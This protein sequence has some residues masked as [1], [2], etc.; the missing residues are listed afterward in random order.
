MTRHSE[1]AASSA[2]GRRCLAYA[3]IS[4]DPDN[5]SEAIDRQMA[6][7]EAV[8][9]KLGWEVEHVID[10]NLSAWKKKGSRPGFNRLIEE[11]ENGWCD[12]IIVWNIDRL[13]RRMDEL[14]EL[15]AA[16][17]KRPGVEIHT[18]GGILQLNDS[19]DRM[20]ARIQVLVAQAESENKSRRVKRARQDK[21]IIR[22][23]MGDDPETLMQ[24][25]T[26]FI[27]GQTT[28]QIARELN[29]EGKYFPMRAKVWRPTSIDVVLKN[30]RLAEF[31][32]PEEYMAVLRRFD[33]RRRA[34]YR[35]RTHTYLLSGIVQ[36]FECGQRMVGAGRKRTNGTIT[37]HYVHGINGTGCALSISPAEQ[38]DLHVIEYVKEELAGRLIVEQER[39]DAAIDP[40]Y[41]Q[42]I[43][44][45]E[46]DYYRHK[47]MS[48]ERFDALMAGIIEDAEAAA[49]P[50]VE[51]LLPITGD[52]LKKFDRAKPAQQ[53]ELL[54]RVIDHVEV[55]RGPRGRKG[56]DPSRVEI[57]TKAL[58]R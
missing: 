22:P 42:R 45:L 28:A 47:R 36:C 44:E 46:E 32:T 33:E 14:E 6:D 1:H 51:V 15:I 16:I 31:V 13:L 56:F 57:H 2:A 43:A 9:K 41:A 34:P 40:I 35:E 37:R 26:R 25:V 10:R 48:R 52:F 23:Y 54:R 7:N 18:A 24:V 53:R 4:R 49:V 20:N 58:R 8:A 50:H 5:V 12:A 11:I 29:A 3:R 55:K 19:G 39:A 30:P 27:D 21:E 38:V 17:E